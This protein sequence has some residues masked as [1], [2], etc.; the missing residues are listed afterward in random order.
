MS[1][2]YEFLIEVPEEKIRTLT[3]ALVDGNI[4]FN[5]TTALMVTCDG[6]YVDGY[7]VPEIV[8]AMNRWWADR[9]I[10]SLPGSMWPTARAIPSIRSSRTPSSNTGPPATAVASL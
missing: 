5:P 6:Y 8:V 2:T 1:N 3:R 4:R 9:G 10:P 7:R